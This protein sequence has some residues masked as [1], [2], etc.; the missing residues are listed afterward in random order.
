MP[1]TTLGIDY[2]VGTVQTGMSADVVI[3]DRHPLEIGARA[4]IVIIEGGVVLNASAD[5]APLPSAPLIPAMTNPSNIPSDTPVRLEKV[6]LLR[7]RVFD[8]RRFR[9]GLQAVIIDCGFIKCLG[10]CAVPSDAVV[11]DLAGGTVMPGLVDVTSSLGTYDIGSEE[12]TATGVS[13]ASYYRLARQG[14]SS[15]IQFATRHLSAAWRAGVTT[16]VS[17][18]RAERFI[19]GQSVAF[20]TGSKSRLDRGAIVRRSTGLHVTIGQAAKDDYLA[21]SIAGQ[22]EYLRASLRS[23]KTFVDYG[24]PWYDV[25]HNNLVLV[26][27]CVVN[28]VKVFF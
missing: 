13:E 1:A 21:G 14:S 24:N 11:F 28:S 25:I 10:N 12:S 26:V 16:A 8:G 20:R 23:G 4:D 18:P 5:A 9:D 19:V 17:A 22:V 2:H 6:A 15:G 7:A 3:W 27:Q